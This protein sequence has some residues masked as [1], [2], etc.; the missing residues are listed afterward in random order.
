MIKH[1]GLVI[2]PNIMSNKKSLVKLKPK[3]D[4]TI[5]LFFNGKRFFSYNR[6]DY[7]SIMAKYNYKDYEFYHLYVYILLI[8]CCIL[9]LHFIIGQ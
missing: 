7:S 4:L 2:S 1:D 3:N 9:L 5:D 6:T 8:I